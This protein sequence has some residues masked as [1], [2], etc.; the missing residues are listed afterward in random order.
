[1]MAKIVLFGV[2]D[3]AE[4]VH[5]YLTHDSGHEVVAFCLT[6]AFLKEDTFRGLP[7]VSFE[8]VQTVYPP[9]ISISMRL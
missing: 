7:V 1:M 4:L 5:F 8:E 2:Q 6:E 3:T 9:P